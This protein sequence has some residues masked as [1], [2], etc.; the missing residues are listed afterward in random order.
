[1]T[2]TGKRA[3]RESG[4]NRHGCHRVNHTRKSSA[5]RRRMGWYGTRRTL[6]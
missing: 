3:R 2:T 4:L 6:Q 1:M 5:K